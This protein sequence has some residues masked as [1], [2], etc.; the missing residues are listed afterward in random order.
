MAALSHLDQLFNHNNCI[1]GDLTSNLDEIL[2]LVM[3][4]R[5]VSGQSLRFLTLTPRPRPSTILAKALASSGSN[6]NPSELMGLKLSDPCV[7]RLKQLAEQKEGTFLRILV[8]GGGCSGFQYKFELDEG[9][10][11]I[12]SDDR[13]FE[14]DGA[15]VVIDET[16]LE[17]LQ[18]K[19]SES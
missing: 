16:S 4:L 8:E 3:A 10:A 5:I 12:E 13:V 17:Y 14:R 1:N 6:P 9:E 15:R 2:G 11:K 18:G 7:Q 19:S